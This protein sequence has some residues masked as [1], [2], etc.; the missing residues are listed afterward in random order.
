MMLSWLDL[1][2]MLSIAAKPEFEEPF[3]AMME[4]WK[5]L[6]LRWGLVESESEVEP[7]MK[8]ESDKLEDTNN[9]YPVGSDPGLPYLPFVVTEVATDKEM[10]IRNDNNQE[11]FH[12]SPSKELPNKTVFKSGF[13][14]N[15]Q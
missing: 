9:S 14:L 15:F 12:I 5:I 3:F 8:S 6:I 7:M 10:I 4:S 1:N 2:S 11:T 13:F